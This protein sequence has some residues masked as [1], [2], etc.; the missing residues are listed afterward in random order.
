MLHNHRNLIFLETSFIPI[1]LPC[2]QYLQED[3]DVWQKV[4]AVK[5][6]STTICNLQVNHIYKFR[7]RAENNFG[8]S[9]P[10]E[11]SESVP[12]ISISS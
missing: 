6:S 7:V 8:Q 2:R 12:F 1:I 10:S 9:D 3:E 5:Q 11:E 4:D